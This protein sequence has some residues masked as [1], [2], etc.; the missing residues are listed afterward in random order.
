MHCNKKMVVDSRTI[1]FAF[2]VVLTALVPLG[3]GPQAAT[4]EGGAHEGVSE[5]ERQLMERAL[6]KQFLARPAKARKLL[7]FDRAL[8][9]RH[10]G[11]PYANLAFTLLGEKTGA[12]SAVVSN[13]PAV[14]ASESIKQYDAV[15]FNDTTGNLFEDLQLRRNLLAFVEG[16]GGLMGLH[17]AISAFVERA[18]T[19]G[20]N[21]ARC[22]GVAV[23]AITWI[24]GVPLP[25]AMRGCGGL[26][27][28]VTKSTPTRCF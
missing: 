17:A 19:S 3:R 6:P 20:R 4:A 22:S 8:E 23:P 27:V 10:A 12:F 21:S 9:F 26:P 25:Q 7:I 2:A 28:P 16:G 18:R 13:D 15:L 14:F 24:G 1:T 5:E 11:I